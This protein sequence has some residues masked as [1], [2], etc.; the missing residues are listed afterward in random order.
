MNIA[1]AIQPAQQNHTAVGFKSQKVPQGTLASQLNQGQLTNVTNSLRKR[2]GGKVSAVEKTVDKKLVTTVE[3]IVE[4]PKFDV[5]IALDV[6]ASMG[7]SKLRDAKEGCLGI[8]NTLHEDDGF[9]VISFACEM[10]KQKL[11]WEENVIYRVTLLKGS[12][13]SNAEE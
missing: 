4:R 2:G 6:S 10:Y 11:S 5:E 12:T 8:F 1:T 13:E 3:E 7:G 9:G